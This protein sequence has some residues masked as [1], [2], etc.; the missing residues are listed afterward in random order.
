ACF[1][2]AVTGSRM[3]PGARRACPDDRL[4]REA[5]A[6]LFVEE[7]REIPG[8]VALGAP[9]E[10]HL[11]QALEDAIRDRARAPESVELALVLDCAQALDD[12]A[13]RHRLDAAA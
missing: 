12:A 8:D 9:D 13:G 5:L 2:R 6:S 11:G 1:D 3:R 10:R 7:L 4:E